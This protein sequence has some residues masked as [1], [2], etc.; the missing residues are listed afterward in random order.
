MR[1][2]V[3]ARAGHSCEYCQTPE[4]ASF[5]AHEMDHVIALKHGGETTLDNLAFSCTLCNRRKGQPTFLR[6]IP[7]PAS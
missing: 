1:D 7:P 5:A 6:S 3:A 2:K 4:Q